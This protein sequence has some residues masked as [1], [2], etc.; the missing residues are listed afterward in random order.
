MH[1]GKAFEGVKVTTAPK[2]FPIVDRCICGDSDWN[3]WSSCISALNSLGL[4]GIETDPDNLFDLKMLEMNGQ[5]LTSGGTPVLCSCSCALLSETAHAQCYPWLILVGACSVG[6]YAPPGAEPDTGV[7][8]NSTYME[9]WAKAQFTRFFAA[10]FTADQLTTFALADEPGWYFPAEA[11]EHFMNASLGA[12][13]AALKTEWQAFLAKNKVT[14]IASEPSTA[15][16]QLNGLTEKKL[17]YW[18]SR[19][20]SYSSAV[21]FGRATAAMEV[22]T[23]KGAPI[24]VNFNNFAGRGYVPGPVGNNRDKTNPDAA[25]LSLDWF[26][27]GR[28]R[29]STLM[30]TEDWFGDSAASQWGYYGARLRSASRLAPSKDVIHGGCL[31]CSR[32]GGSHSVS[33]LDLCT[34]VGVRS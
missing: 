34:A 3:D 21:A 31:L 16:W 29:G 5:H 23:R 11:P 19:F 15:R 33:S 17:F 2:Q 4:N 28:A 6:I 13:A 10:G 24:Y 27:F 7:T 32:T 9:Q 18:S 14:G 30:W 12:R 1:V 25:M 22:A 8:L 26:E 20:S